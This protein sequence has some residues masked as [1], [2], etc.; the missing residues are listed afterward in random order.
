MFLRW[1]FRSATRR[2]TTG[3]HWAWWII[4]ASTWLLQRDRNQRDRAAI[5]MP[6]KPGQQ[7]LV[8]MNED[9]EISL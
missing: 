5:S 9:G 2:A 3:G 7:V 1:V 4:V 6:I 8:T